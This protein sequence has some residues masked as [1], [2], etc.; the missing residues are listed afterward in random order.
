VGST[1]CVQ[2]DV[3]DAI[4]YDRMFNVVHLETTFKFH[5]YPAL[6]DPLRLSA[7]SRKRMQ[8]CPI[9]GAADLLLPVCAA[10]D[11]VLA[12]LR[13]YRD[14]GGVSEKQWDDLSGLIQV[15]GPRLDRLYL[16]EWASRA[17]LEELLGRLMP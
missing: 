10:E 15:S 17:R 16:Q 14:G 1:A 5:I 9:P 13:W 6:S 11:I 12:K 3:E 4:R 8:P 7:L 2:Q